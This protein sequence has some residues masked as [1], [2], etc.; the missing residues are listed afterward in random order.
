MSIIKD[1]LNEIIGNCHRLLEVNERDIERACNF[2]LSAQNIFV[3]GVGRSG[4]I[5]RA[6]AMRLAQLGLKA[7]IIGETITPVVSNKDVV[8]L[9]SGT[10]ESQGALLVEQISKRVDAKVVSITASPN[11]SMARNSDLT[12]HIP[13]NKSSNLAPLGTL[14]EI[15]ALML[16]DAMIALLMHLKGET[17]ED[18]RRRHAIWL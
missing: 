16:L 3:Y 14:F 1:S 8:I 12:I 9:I 7:Y 11:S 2:I 18:L 6:F 5:G 17:E 15:S 4:I 13:A 10:G